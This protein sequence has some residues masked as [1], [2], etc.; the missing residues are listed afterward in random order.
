MK[1]LL[2]LCALAPF[3]LLAACGGD[4]AP[5]WIDVRTLESTDP[6]DEAAEASTA[7]VPDPCTLVSSEELSTVLGSEQGAGDLQASDATVRQ[8]CSYETGT[9]LSVEDAA[10]YEASV[11]VIREN[12]AGSTIEDVTG[13][14]EA[15]IWQDFGGAVGQLVVLDGDYF[16]GVSIPAGGT[17]GKV[18][19]ESVAEA[20]LAAI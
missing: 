9:I 12:G 3:G 2:V 14:G 10:N 18:V 16:V 1:R 20:M 19:A 4:D 6:T 13:I 15:A 5:E 7:D 17:D 8:V 11:A